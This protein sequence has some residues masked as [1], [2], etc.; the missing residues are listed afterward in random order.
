M[1]VVVMRLITAL[2]AAAMLGVSAPAAAHVGPGGVDVLLGATL[3]RTWSWQADSPCGEEVGEGRR[4]VRLRTAARTSLP[5]DGGT[6]RVVGTLETSGS[7]ETWE[8]ENRSCVAR[9]QRCPTVRRPITGSVQ[10]RIRGDAVALS[11]LR[12]RV[13]GRPGCAPEVAEVRAVLRNEPRLER[14]AVR[15]REHKLRNARIPRL[16][17][18]ASASPTQELAGPVTGKVAATVRWTLNLTRR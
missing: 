3:A 11:S 12:Y 2:A 4:V 7:A 17:V 8:D 18:R 15:D 10:V 9:T 16:T 6:V 5:G 1:V 13:V 14:V